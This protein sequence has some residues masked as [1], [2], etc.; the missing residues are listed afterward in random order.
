MKISY[1]HPR[2]GNRTSISL[3]D[4]FIR[5]WGITIGHDT[6]TDDFMSDSSVKQEIH[7]YIIGL[8]GDYRE[9]MTTFTTLVAYVENNIIVNAEDVI[10]Q[11][12]EEKE[13]ID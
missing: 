1:T 10:R 4:G 12:R 6:S 7:D 2:T 11:L 5:L 3:S 9:D 13:L 8:A